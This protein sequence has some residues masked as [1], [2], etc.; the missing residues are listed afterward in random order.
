MPDFF[1]SKNKGADSGSESF[2]YKVAHDLKNPIISMYGL[3]SVLKNKSKDCTE[4]QKKLIDRIIV[5]AEKMDKL[6]EDLLD[7]EKQK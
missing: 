2:V 5:N 6:V 1:S 7:Q 4:E 3:A